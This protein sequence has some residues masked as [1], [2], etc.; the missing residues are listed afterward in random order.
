MSLLLQPLVATIL[1]SFSVM[2]RS[3]GFS[4]K[5]NHIVFAFETWVHVAQAGL[6]LMT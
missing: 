1:L 4:E 2:F 6:E 5:F 3:P